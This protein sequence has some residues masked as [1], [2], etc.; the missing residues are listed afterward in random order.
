MSN[1]RPDRLFDL[2]TLTTLVK[3]Y[4]LLATASLGCVIGFS[5]GGYGYT[6]DLEYGWGKG[7]VEVKA[8]GEYDYIGVPGSV[9]SAGS[10]GTIYDVQPLASGYEVKG[11]SVEG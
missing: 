10:A 7:A 6:V 1:R 8:M 5:S 9:Y 3:R 4:A 2:T 11:Y